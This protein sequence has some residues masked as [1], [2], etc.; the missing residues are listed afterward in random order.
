MNLKPSSPQSLR[1]KPTVPRYNL[2]TGIDKVRSALVLDGL[3]QGKTQV[4]NHQQH[5]ALTLLWA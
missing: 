3:K 2:D 4:S 5:S 1:L